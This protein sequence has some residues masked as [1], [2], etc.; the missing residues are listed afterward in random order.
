MQENNSLLLKNARTVFSDRTEMRDVRIENGIIADIAC[1]I[2]PKDNEPVIDLDG[3]ILMPGLIDTHIHGGLSR[4]FFHMD[5]DLASITQA[6]A[7]R[8]VTAIAPTYSCM[9]TDLFC[10]SANRVVRF[11]KTQNNGAK[12]AGI[13]AE[14]PFLNLKRKG[15][16]IAEYIAK[17]DMEIFNRMVLACEGELKMITLA[18][19]IEGNLDIIS[20]A[21]KLGIAVSAGHTDADA[22]QMKRAIDAGVTRMT[23]TFNAARP[24]NH[25]EPGVLAAAL[26]DSRIN[27]EVI[28]DF[29]HLHPMTVEMIYK[30]K[31]AD[32]FT[33]VSDY[34]DRDGLA[35]KGEGEHTVN[36]MTY[37]II[38]GVAWS[39]DGAVLSNS[40]DLMVGAK[41]LYSLGI[42]LWDISKMAAQNPAKALGIFDRTSSIAVG[43]AADLI[44]VDNEFDLHYTFID[45]RTVFKA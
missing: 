19:E 43:K 42:P 10:A 35:G 1:A 14:G 15:G 9:P 17:P 2:E 28:C 11:G 13:H 41:N 31:G 33:V 16:M 39:K 40:N 4:S 25:R 6:Y 21:Q 20:A 7:R 30:L 24:I 34:S 26:T 18:P 23:H 22:K 12:I 45:G 5:A 29:A 27:C 8:G 44:A 3:K 36:G 37:D 32:G 38:R